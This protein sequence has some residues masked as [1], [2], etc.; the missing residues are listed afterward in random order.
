M[1]WIRSSS[2]LLLLVYFAAIIVATAAMPPNEHLQ[3][4]KFALIYDSKSIT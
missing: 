4:R 2:E 1:Y 3:V